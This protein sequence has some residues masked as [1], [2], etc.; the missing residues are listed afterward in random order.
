MR[1]QGHIAPFDATGARFEAFP[2][3]DIEANIVDGTSLSIDTQAVFII[4][5]CFYP[6]RNAVR[7]LL[8]G[9]A[10]SRGL[11]DNPENSQSCSRL[12]RAF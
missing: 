10:R 4:R 8:W 7:L 12:S 5:F 11:I 2:S 6:L 9:A 3:P 1:S